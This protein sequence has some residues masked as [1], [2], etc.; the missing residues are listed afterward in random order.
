M[1]ET[2]TCIEV[3]IEALKNAYDESSDIE[4]RKSI[5]AAFKAVIQLSVSLGNI[6]RTACTDNYE[7]DCDPSELCSAV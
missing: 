6:E 7:L 1:A 2:N 3:A 5:I 4:A